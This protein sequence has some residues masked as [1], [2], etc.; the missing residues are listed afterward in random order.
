MQNF[1]RDEFKRELEGKINENSDLIDEYD[2]FEKTFLLVLKKYAPIKTKILRASHVPHMIKTLR[3]AIMKRA[4]L[5]TKY[6]LKVYKKQRNFHFTKKEKYYNKLNM[7]SITNNREFSK[8]IKQFLSDKVT[9]Q[10]KISLVE[11]GKLL[12]NETKAAETFNNFF[13]NVVDKLGINRDDVKFNDETVLSTNPVDIAIQ[14]FNPPSVKLIREN[15]T[16]SDM[17]QFENVFL[18]DILKE[19]TNLNP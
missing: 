19:I 6:N 4:E 11:N 8:T 7:N 15:I 14:K 13:E 10:T 12:L 2:F 9:A 1:N 3:K 5:Q 16:L 18:D 17:F